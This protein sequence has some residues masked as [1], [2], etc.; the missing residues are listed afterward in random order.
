VAD[1]PIERGL[2]PEDD[3][4][5][6]DIDVQLPPADRAACFSLVRR[7]PSHGPHCTL[8]PET[9]IS[10]GPPELPTG[11][12]YVEA[13]RGLF[14]LAESTRTTAARLGAFA[15]KAKYDSRELTKN[16]RAASPGSPSYFEREVDP[17]GVLDPVERARRAEY[18]RKA[19][20][21]GLALRSAKVRAAR[22]AGA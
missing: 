20:F 7:L 3:H 16:A 18:A 4:P 1:L 19:Y 13:D 9:A 22:K 10:N 5:D 12:P 21:T 6:D 15:Q 17:D 14:L 2:L 8:C 11:T